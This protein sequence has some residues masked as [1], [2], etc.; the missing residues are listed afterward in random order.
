MCAQPEMGWGC[1]LRVKMPSQGIHPLP[2]Q[3]PVGMV[4][5][6]KSG[7]NAGHHVQTEE[8]TELLQ[9]LWAT[10][11]RREGESEHTE[12]I[13]SSLFSIQFGWVAVVMKL[14]GGGW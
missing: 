6:Y 9:S 8:G 1:L 14:G 3:A 10:A 4:R 11:P 2:T 7:S 13:W 12:V 5:K